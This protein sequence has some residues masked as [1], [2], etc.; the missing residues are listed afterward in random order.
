[1]DVSSIATLVILYCI[2]FVLGVVP[3][4]WDPDS[5]FV[6]IELRSFFEVATELASFAGVTTYIVQSLSCWKI[7]DDGRRHPTQQNQA[8]QIWLTGYTGR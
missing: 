2:S 6:A 8:H 7:N 3:G 5:C 1:M 4:P